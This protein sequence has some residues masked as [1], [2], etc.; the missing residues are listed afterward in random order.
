M[1]NI[2]RAT[3]IRNYICNIQTGLQHVYPTLVQYKSELTEK[4]SDCSKAERKKV[5]AENLIK[6][7][8]SNKKLIKNVR[9]TTFMARATVIAAQYS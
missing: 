5:K 1:Y 7:Q 4:I 3:P 8:T 9:K 6:E 2:S